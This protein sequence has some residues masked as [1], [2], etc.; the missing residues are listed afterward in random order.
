MADAK[1]EIKVVVDGLD[2]DKINKKI[3]E[4]KAEIAKKTNGDGFAGL[5]KD[6]KTPRKNRQYKN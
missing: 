1:L 4:L 6:L 2:V 3:K 5:K